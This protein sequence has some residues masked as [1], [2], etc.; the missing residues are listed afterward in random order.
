MDICFYEQIGEEAKLARLAWA[1]E[2]FG[3]VRDSNDLYESLLLHTLEDYI[4]KV[5][6]E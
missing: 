5:L 3:D 4:L 2:L 6:E 1:K